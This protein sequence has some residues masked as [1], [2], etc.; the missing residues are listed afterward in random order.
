[1][2]IYKCNKACAESERNVPARKRRGRAGVVVASSRRL[3]NGAAPLTAN[4]YALIKRNN[5]KSAVHADASLTQVGERQMSSAA[6]RGGRLCLFVARSALS[7]ALQA[8]NGTPHNEDMQRRRR[9]AC[10]VASTACRKCYRLQ[11]D[12]L[13]VHG[14][15]RRNLTFGYAPSPSKKNR[16]DL[17]ASDSSMSTNYL[18]NI[19][20]LKGRENYDDWCFATENV[21]ILEGMADA[22]KELLSPTATTAQKS[23]NMKARAKLILTIDGSLFVHIRNTTTTYDLWQTL[24]NMFD[25]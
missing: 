3:V 1:M 11:R 13:M 5:A 9:S 10:N 25:D 21:L 20:K 17:S 14:F 24:K 7:L 2:Y 22:I 18:V 4:L 23:D 19:P 16:C 8:L 15:N 12:R 6:E